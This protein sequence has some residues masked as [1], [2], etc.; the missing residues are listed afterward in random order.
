MP[1]FIVMNE[2]QANQ[3]RGQTTRAHACAPIP[4]ANTNPVVFVLPVEIKA[5]PFHQ[6]ILALLNSFSTATIATLDRHPDDSLNQ[7][8]T[9]N[10][11]TWTVGTKIVV[12]V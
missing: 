2:A 10:E 6:N 4:I 11:S 5:D 8:C 1:S 7:R 3:V 12:T 9:F